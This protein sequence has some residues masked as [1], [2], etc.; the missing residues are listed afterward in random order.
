MSAPGISHGTNLLQDDVQ[1]EDHF[2]EQRRFCSW[3]GKNWHENI[4]I[5]KYSEL[6][7]RVTPG[8]KLQLFA[9]SYK[10][11]KQEFQKITKYI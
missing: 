11:L 8:L 7:S 2:P 6:S 1:R 10:I 5:N 9:G 4:S 3:K